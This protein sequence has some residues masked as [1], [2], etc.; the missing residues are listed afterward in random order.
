MTQVLTVRCA[1]RCCMGETNHRKIVATTAMSL[2]GPLPETPPGTGIEE[3]LQQRQEID[4][5]LQEKFRRDVTILFTDIQGSTA[6]FAQRGDVDGRLMI[7]RHNDLLFPIITA[8]EGTVVKIIGDAIMA[9]FQAP[10]SAV[11]AAVAMQRALRDANRQQEAAKQIHIRIGINSGYGLVESHDVFGDV[12]NVAARVV[13]R[14][15]H[16]QILIAKATYDR[17]PDTVPCQPLGAAT[18]KGK[19]TPLDVFEVLWNDYE[20]LPPP[21]G[22]LV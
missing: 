13:S 14:T 2:P 10:L 15:L 8:H 12:V 4:A 3:L 21:G 22:G 11:R 16:D 9:S 17:L 20:P 1:S 19:E 5:L 6:Y 18:V 7:K